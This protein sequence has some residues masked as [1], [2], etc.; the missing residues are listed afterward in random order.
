MK[1]YLIALSFFLFT[2]VW[3]MESGAAIVKKVSDRGWVLFTDLGDCFFFRGHYSNVTI[4][5]VFKYS[6]DNVRYVYELHCEGRAPV[7]LHIE[8]TRTMSPRLMRVCRSDEDEQL[9]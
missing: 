7:I 5:S 8:E 1:M 9:R 2:S 4:V 6:E 3:V